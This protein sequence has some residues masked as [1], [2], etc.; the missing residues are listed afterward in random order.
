M[1]TSYFIRHININPNIHRKRGGLYL[2]KTGFG[3]INSNS[4][5]FLE[6]G[7]NILGCPITISKN[8]KEWWSN[9]HNIFK[10]NPRNNTTSIPLFWKKNHK[11]FLIGLLNINS[12]KKK[13]VTLTKI[14]HKNTDVFLARRTKLG[15]YFP[16]N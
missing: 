7:H 9:E 8:L 13:Y 6:Y 11:K 15:G 1:K 3:R 14:I 12:L 4:I 16:N 5:I 2:N 10:G